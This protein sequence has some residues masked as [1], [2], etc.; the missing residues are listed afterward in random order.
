VRLFA[1]AITNDA[2]R[3]VYYVGIIHFRGVK[4]LVYSLLHVVCVRAGSSGL[5]FMIIMALHILSAADADGKATSLHS[6]SSSQVP[7]E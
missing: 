1:F 3:M 7:E 2:L 6:T 4:W 5:K